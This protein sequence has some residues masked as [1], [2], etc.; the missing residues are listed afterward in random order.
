MVKVRLRGPLRH[1]RPLLPL[2]FSLVAAVAYCPHMFRASHFPRAR[3][4]P[5]VAV[6]KSWTTVTL[7]STTPNVAIGFVFQ[8]ASIC[9][10]F[11][12]I[13]TPLV[14][15][16]RWLNAGFDPIGKD[17]SKS[18]QYHDET[19]CIHLPVVYRQ[20][21][22]TQTGYK[23]TAFSTRRALLYRER[24]SIKCIITRRR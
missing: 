14:V 19:A 13:I 23:P 3:A 11:H 18:R 10:Y 12:R 24:K 20:H 2:N 1:F 5:L 9:A 7:M 17:K 15:V 22:S 4:T 8:G 6:A 16:S 21:S